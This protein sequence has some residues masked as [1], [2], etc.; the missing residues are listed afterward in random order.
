M[1][2]RLT[3]SDG[4]VVYQSPLLL[5]VGVPHAFTTRLG[6]VS[7]GPYASLNLG[8]GCREPVTDPTTQ[9]DRQTN[10]DDNYQRL[11]RV[12]GWQTHRR[13]WVNQVHGG[14]VH[15]VRLPSD[16]QP[17]QALT[18]ADALVTDQRRLILTIRVADCVPILL[19]DRQHR[20]VAAVHAGWRSLIKGVVINTLHSLSHHYHIKPSELVAAVGP[21]ISLHHLEVGHDV[22]G[23][24]HQAQLSQHVHTNPGPKP[25]VDLSG[26]VH[27][28]LRTAGVHDDAID[29]T[30]RCTFR[31]ANEFFSH[32]RDQGITGRMAA[33]IGV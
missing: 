26:A 11:M 2:M 13:A 6:G 23:A 12:M 24:F 10:V 18:E 19:A 29:M 3:L 9:G 22:A 17:T 28:Q 5:G 30:D 32:R 20:V 1:L 33:L 4:V 31:D 7:T 15:P 16:D 14:S 21:A 8:P 25:H 27:T